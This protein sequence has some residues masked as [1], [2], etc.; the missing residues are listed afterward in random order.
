MRRYA[1]LLLVSIAVGVCG[2]ITA[3]QVAQAHECH[4]DRQSGSRVC[5][6]TRVMPNW[7]DNYVPLFGLEDRGDKQQRYDAQRWRD[8]CDGQQNCAWVEGGSSGFPNDDGSSPSPNELHAGY[9]A[10]HC[11]LAE[12]AHQCEGHDS[13]LGEGV[14][15]AHGGAIYADVCLARNRENKWCNDG[16]EDTQVGLTIMDH[17]PCGTVVP[18]VACTDEY[19]VVRPLDG[20]YTAAQMENTGRAPQG[21][22]ERPARYVCGKHRTGR[23]CRA[24]VNGV[25]GAGG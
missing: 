9:A 19:H 15:D 4:T 2:V 22:A 16:L 11:F 20:E 7:R 12:A 18:V 1:F 5:R 23:Q 10:S 24:Q 14:H 3:T 21:V 6:D 25:L 8:E 13:S 17:N